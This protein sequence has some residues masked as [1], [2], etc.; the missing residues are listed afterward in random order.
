[1]RG[2][3]AA[4]QTTER[5]KRNRQTCRERRK[6][7]EVEEGRYYRTGEIWTRSRKVREKMERL[8]GTGRAPG[9]SR[10]Q[11]NKGLFL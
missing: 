11:L 4:R 6:D 3:E 1:M 9:L 2:A 7:G 10:E 5:G 8:G